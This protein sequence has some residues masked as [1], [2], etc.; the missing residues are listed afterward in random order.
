[1]NDNIKKG[2][3]FWADIPVLENSR[4]QAGYRPVVITSN[5]YATKYSEAIQYMPLTTKIKKTNLPV[6]VVVTPNFLKKPSMVLAEQEG[7]IDKHRLKEKIGTLGK[8]DVLKIDMAKIIQGGI[9]IPQIIQYQN[10]VQ[11]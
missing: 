1:M 4:I 10:A 7:I 9:S 3:I 8:N 5:K 6:H 2:D 11:L